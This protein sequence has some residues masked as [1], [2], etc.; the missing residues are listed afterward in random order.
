MSLHEDED[1]HH[2]EWLR[3]QAID[4]DPMSCTFD[5]GDHKS[6]Q[7]I[8][9]LCDVIL[10]KSGLR[11]NVTSAIENFDGSLESKMKAEESVGKMTEFLGTDL[12]PG[13]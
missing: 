5:T 9:R 7:E 4:L 12:F 6:G 3:I 13:G 2:E 11:E 10:N 1:K 8:G